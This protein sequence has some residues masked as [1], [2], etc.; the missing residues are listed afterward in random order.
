MPWFSNFH[1]HGHS[2]VCLPWLDSAWARVWFLVGEVL[3]LCTWSAYW[4]QRADKRLWWLLDVQSKIFSTTRSHQDHTM[5]IS[6]C[7]WPF[8]PD[9]N[10]RDDL[11]AIPLAKDNSQHTR[12]LQELWYMSE[13][14][15]WHPKGSWII[16]FTTCFWSAMAV[17]SYQPCIQASRR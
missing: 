4:L 17:N 13:F 12:V 6:R 16:C 7:M 14:Q 8:Q 2:Y 15:I 10:T 5:R 3:A 9:T 1:Y 11:G